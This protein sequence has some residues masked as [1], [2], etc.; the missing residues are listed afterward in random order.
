MTLIHQVLLPPCLMY[1]SF[2]CPITNNTL[3]SSDIWRR[4]HRNS[5]CLPILARQVSSD[6]TLSSLFLPCPPFPPCL[7]NAHFPHC[8]YNANPFLP[9]STLPTL[10]SLSLQCPPFP[11]CLYTIRPFLLAFTMPTLSSLSQQYPPFPPC[12]FPPCP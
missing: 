7:Y 12:L 11:P 6:L 3:K 5:Y 4:F 2:S 9:V 1:R 10:S 8:L